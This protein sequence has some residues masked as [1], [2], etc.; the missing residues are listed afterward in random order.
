MIQGLE[1]LLFVQMWLTPHHVKQA[2]LIIM[3]IVLFLPKSATS[4][5]SSTMTSAY[6]WTTQRPALKALPSGKLLSQGAPRRKPRA[7]ELHFITTLSILFNVNHYC[8]HLAA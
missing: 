1:K 8:R 7:R 6:C 4:I 3:L 5:S 2:V